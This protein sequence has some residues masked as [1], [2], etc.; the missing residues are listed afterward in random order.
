MYWIIKL[1]FLILKFF[2]KGKYFMDRYIKQT[3]LQNLACMPCQSCLAHTSNAVQKNRFCN[4]D[5]KYSICIRIFKRASNYANKSF[6]FFIYFF[7]WVC[8]FV[9]SYFNLYFGFISIYFDGA[10]LCSSN[11]FY[12]SLYWSSS[13]RPRDTI[14]N[15]YLMARSVLYIY[16]YI[17]IHVY[18]F[19]IHYKI[20]DLPIDCLIVFCTSLG[21]LACRVCPEQIDLWTRC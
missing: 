2:R 19:K 21:N 4:R 1:E 13:D 8:R 17:H 12:Q 16:I 10:V 7:N 18:V 6:C 9:C 15:C 14:T 20:R 5:T 11:V 3:T